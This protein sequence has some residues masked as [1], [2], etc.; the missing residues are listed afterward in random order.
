MDELPL[1]D[2]TILV[3]GAARQIGGERW[4]ACAKAGA[5]IVAHYHHSSH[6]AEE[7]HQELATMGRSTWLVEGD[8]NSEVDIN[9]VALGAILLL[10]DQAAN[11][12]LPGACR[13]AAGG[14]AG[15]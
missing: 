9:A 13:P 15:S 2:R 12:D 8:L 1:R 4:C 11:P 5:N 10:S 3:T 6:D 7:L 14:A